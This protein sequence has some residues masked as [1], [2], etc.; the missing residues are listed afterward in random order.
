MQTSKL[1]YFRP[2]C[3]IRIIPS[4]FQ[5]K[6]TKYTGVQPYM[7]MKY[8]KLYIVFLNKNC[9]FRYN[10]RVVS[11][12]FIYNR[13]NNCPHTKRLSYLHTARNAHIN[14]NQYLNSTNYENLSLYNWRGASAHAPARPLRRWPHSQTPWRKNAD[15]ATSDA[16]VRPTP[17]RALAS[18]S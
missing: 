17:C 7:K 8:T 9:L 6:N 4:L 15:S 2:K 1:Q 5:K 13:F 11:Q 16:R 14:H 18:S 12:V 10:N 3:Q